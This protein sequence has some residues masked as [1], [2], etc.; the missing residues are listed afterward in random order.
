MTSLDLD[1]GPPGCR[2]KMESLNNM[3]G[4][5][6]LSS[7]PVLL[8][9]IFKDANPEASTLVGIDSYLSLSGMSKTRGGC[10]FGRFGVLHV[11]HTRLGKNHNSCKH[12]LYDLFISTGESALLGNRVA[13]CFPVMAP[14]S[15]DPRSRCQIKRML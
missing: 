6:S 7:H 12:L 9:L 4:R 13:I 5:K 3:A 2:R 11:T 15:V 8:L 14:K 10:D 1:P